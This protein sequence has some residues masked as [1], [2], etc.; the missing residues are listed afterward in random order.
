MRAEKDDPGV[1]QF[2]SVEFYASWAWVR[3][4]FFNV[5]NL[6]MSQNVLSEGPFL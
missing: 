1:S 5:N 3:L 4:F 6:G 2:Q